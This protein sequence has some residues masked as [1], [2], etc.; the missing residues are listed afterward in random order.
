MV[1]DCKM[2]MVTVHTGQAEKS[3]PDVVSH[4]LTPVTAHMGLK[5]QQSTEFSQLGSC[6][7]PHSVTSSVVRK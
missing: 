3:K 6:L 5:G 7:P 2:C 4:L 1:T